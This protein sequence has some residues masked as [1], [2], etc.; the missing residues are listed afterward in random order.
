MGL[1]HGGRQAGT[2]G[3]KTAGPGLSHD[4]GTQRDQQYQQRTTGELKEQSRLKVL[5]K[6]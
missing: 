5:V 2:T 1:A 6:K 3:G 4:P